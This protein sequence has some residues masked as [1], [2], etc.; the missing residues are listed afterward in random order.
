MKKFSKFNL[1][2]PAAKVLMVATIVGGLS[3]ASHSVHAAVTPGY[4]NYVTD[5]FKVPM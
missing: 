4:T 3:L 5:T 1:A 2:T